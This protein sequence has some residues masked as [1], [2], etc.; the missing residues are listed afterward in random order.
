[1]LKIEP[2]LNVGLYYFPPFAFTESKLGVRP[3]VLSL[4]SCS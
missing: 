4:L 2:M 3:M 1:M